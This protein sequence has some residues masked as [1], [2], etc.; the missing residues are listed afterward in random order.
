MEYVMFNNNIIFCGD[1]FNHGY[2]ILLSVLDYK[3]IPCQQ[4][5]IS[6][7]RIYDICYFKMLSLRLPRSAFPEIRLQTYIP[8][9]RFFVI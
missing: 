5:N 1:L 6:A 8:G 7:G 2:F 3:I 9:F 4:I